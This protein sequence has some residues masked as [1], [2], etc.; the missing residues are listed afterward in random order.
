MDLGCRACVMSKDSAIEWTH[1][2]FNPWW[3]C[4]KV[5]EG[6]RECYAEDIREPT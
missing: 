6:C 1:D 5:S 3:G 2:T 4:E